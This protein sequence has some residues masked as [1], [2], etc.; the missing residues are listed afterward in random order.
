[1]ADYIEKTNRKMLEAMAQARTGEHPEAEAV[2]LDEMIHR[3]QFILP[4]QMVT[5]GDSRKLAYAVAQDKQGQQFY[6][7]FTDKEKL[8]AWSGDRKVTTTVHEFGECA[9]LAMGDSRIS[10]FVINANTT[11]MIIGRKMIEELHSRQVAEE[12]GMTAEPVNPQEAAEYRE[13]TADTKDLERALRDYFRRDA[14]VA[15]AYLKEVVKQ[16]RTDWLVIIRHLE[17][18]DPTFTNVMLTAKPYLGNR[19]LALLSAR[20]SVAKDAI[21][22]TAPFYRKPFSVVE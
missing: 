10:G 21:G 5:G 18:I 1:M 7:L 14:N 3:A 2:M 4:V 19:G 13:P 20:S 15:E 8:K 6:L 16:G 9:R 11:N 22:E 12:R 17:G